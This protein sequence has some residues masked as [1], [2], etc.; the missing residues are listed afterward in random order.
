MEI[1]DSVIERLILSLIIPVVRPN[2]VKVLS[3]IICSSQ[4]KTLFQKI[5]PRIPGVLHNIQH[6]LN[7]NDPALPPDIQLAIDLITACVQKYAVYDNE[8]VSAIV[9]RQSLR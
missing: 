6:N 1:A 5:V 3:H 2:S 9:L 8:I 7:S 4:S